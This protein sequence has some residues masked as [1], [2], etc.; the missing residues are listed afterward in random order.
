[1]AKQQANSGETEAETAG[2]SAQIRLNTEGIRAAI[3]AG[4]GITCAGDD[5]NSP[6]RRARMPVLCD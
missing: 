6:L 1:M 3:D 4:I 5:A 2:F